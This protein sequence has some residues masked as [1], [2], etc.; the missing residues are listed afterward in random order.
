[1]RILFFLIFSAGLVSCLPA[2]SVAPAVE[3]LKDRYP[4]Y[5]EETITTRRFVIE[6]LI[7]L[8][9][10]HNEQPHFKI[11]VKGKSLQQRPIYLGRYGHGK[12]SLLFWSQMHGDESTATMALLDLFNYF[13]SD[14]PADQSFLQSLRDRFTLYFIPMLNP[15]GVAKFQRR[16]AANIDLNRDA[17]HLANPESRLLKKVRD[18]VSPL[19]GFNL[20]DQSIY[21]RAGRDGEQVAITFLAPVYDYEK[22]IND[23]RLRAMQLISVLRD[24]LQ[25][26]IP[27]RIG[28]YDDTFEPRAFGDNIQKWGTSTIL[29][30]SGGYPDDPEKQYLRKLNFITLIKSLESIM[31]GSYEQKTTEEYHSIPQNDRK[32]MSLILQDLTVPVHGQ[33]VRMDVGYQY[34]ERV[35]DGKTY[36]ISSI[37]DTGDLSIYDG[38]K[39]TSAEDMTL[40]PGKWY[41]HPFSSIRELKKGN[42]EDLIREGYL[43]FLVEELPDNLLHYPFSLASELPEG[44]SN[45]LDPVIAPGRNPSFFLKK[46]EI[47]QVV[48]NGRIFTLEKYLKEV[49]EAFEE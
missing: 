48:H 2:Q 31:T 29:I 13:A 8:F 39:E 47:K 23:V 41:P 46:G 34:F 42:P 10:K 27:D 38:F 18:S 19:F 7:P 37:Q 6:D 32:M 44:R 30:E 3:E 24:S 25:S 26:E 12:T 45:P 21:Y 20:H 28:V 11:G 22:S 17:I 14:H 40:L 49:S 1:M 36:Y 35:V 5:M 9:E 16:N 43:G 4:L 33:S 15:D